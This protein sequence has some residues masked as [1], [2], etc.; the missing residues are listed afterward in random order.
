VYRGLE[1]IAQVEKLGLGVEAEP[2]PQSHVRAEPDVPMS[3]GIER[4]ERLGQRLVERPERLSRQGTGVVKHHRWRERFGRTEAKIGRRGAER[5]QPSRGR[6]QN[7]E[8]PNQQ[9][10]T[11]WGHARF[12]SEARI[13]NIGSN[14]PYVRM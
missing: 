6:R 4:G 1:T 9:V 3:L 7:I 2:V 14:A 13:G 11:R 10:A 8:Q 5:A 12:T